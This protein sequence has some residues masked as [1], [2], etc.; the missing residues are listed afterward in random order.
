MSRVGKKPI[1]IP[2]GVKTVIGQQGV[3]TVEG[4][5]G[6]VEYTPTD[7]VKVS[8]KDS[9]MVVQP[10][11]ESSQAELDYGTTRSILNSMVVGVTKGWKRSLELNGVGFTATVANNVLTLVVGFSHDV[12][13]PIPKGVTCKVTKN[14]IDLE[15]SNKQVIG[16][17]AASIRRVYPPEPYLGKGIKYSDETIRRKAGKTGA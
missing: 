8:V 14:V 6:K 11:N 5:K 9:C 15:S 17:F 13:M 10:I 16:E 1:E 12:K 4:P 7:N 3:I 2:A